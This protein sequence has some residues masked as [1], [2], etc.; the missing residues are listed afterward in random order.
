MSSDS[1]YTDF[2]ID[3]TSGKVESSTQYKQFK[4]TIR[5]L[6]L[7]YFRK[8]EEYNMVFC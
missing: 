2:Q 4:N 3:K 1:E 5:K 8:R 6:I 7:F